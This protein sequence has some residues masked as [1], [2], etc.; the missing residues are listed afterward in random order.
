VMRDEFS[1]DTNLDDVAKVV[2][3]A[4]ANK[5]RLQ[6][7]IGWENGQPAP[8]LTGLAQWAKTFGPGGTHWAGKSDAYAITDIELGNENAFSYK[9][10]D[11]DSSGYTQLAE[12]YG[13]RALAAAKAIDAA[14]PAVKVLLELDSGDTDNDTWITGVMKT[15]GTE[16]TT[17]MRGPTIHPYGPDWQQ[18]VDQDRKLL[19]DHGVDKP[20]YLTEWG[21]STDNGDNIGDNYGYPTTLTYDAAGA[22]LTTA[23]TEMAA[24]PDAIAQ[25]LIYQL[26]DQQDPGRGEREFY[27]GVLNSSGGD[28]GG[29]T[30]A[31]R[32]AIKTYG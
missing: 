27:F 22:A 1:I 16:L 2:D 12:A 32:A 21:I 29:Y 31:I 14:N 3:A 8:D 23:V 25:L 5:V 30:A 9:S 4:A 28:K 19:L 17:L 11:A 15:G 20:F 26:G 6:P 7:L 24:M 18:K 13:T 10:G